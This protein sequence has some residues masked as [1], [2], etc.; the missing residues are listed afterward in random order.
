MAVVGLWLFMSLSGP[1]IV[2]LYGL[3]LL[4]LQTI[5]DFT[6]LFHRFMCLYWDTHERV[7]MSLS[8]GQIKKNMC[9]CGNPTLLYFPGET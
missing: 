6:T 8:L 2:L 3:F 9:V 4:L 1:T 5:T 7:T